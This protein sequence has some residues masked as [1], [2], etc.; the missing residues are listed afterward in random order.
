MVDAEEIRLLAT[1]HDRLRC[2]LAALDFGFPPSAVH[3]DAHPG[4]LLY[5]DSGEVVLLDFEAFCYG[6]R[7]WDLSLTGAYRHG[8]NWLDEAKYAE[9]V[10]AYGFDV[11][12]WNG[13][14]VLRSIRELGMTTWLMQLVDRDPKFEA[15]FSQRIADL[16]TG[17]MPRQ[18]RPF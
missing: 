14:S 13:F 4:N 16:L 17:E 8:F 5:T 2:E 1:L 11:S 9:F 18:W 12:R 6:P 10:R 7:E 15:E 3:G